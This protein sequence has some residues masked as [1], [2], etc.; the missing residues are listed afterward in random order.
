MNSIFKITVAEEPKIQD[1]KEKANKELNE[2]FNEKWVYNTPKVFIVD[3]RKTIDLLREDKT[4]DWVVGW[5][6]GRS[7]IFIL[8]PLN[9]SKESCHDGSKYNIEQL[10]KHELCH[11][12]LQKIFGSSKFKWISEGV[13]LYTAGQ[14]GNY[15]TPKKFD[16]FLNDERIYQESGYAIK[17]LIEKFGKDK[18]FEFLKKQSDTSE[19]EKLETVFKEIFG[20]KMDYSFFN[21][22]IS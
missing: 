12:F 15:K 20:A 1:Y 11:S 19:T 9:I 18:L 13:S 7:A 16:G 3:N 2:F 4:K 22:L 8:N 21:K 14:L 5:G 10:I 17:L 6:W